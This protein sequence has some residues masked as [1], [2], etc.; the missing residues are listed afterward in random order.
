MDKE[1]YKIECALAAMK[2]YGWGSPIGV[3]IF[4]LSAGFLMYMIRLTF[5]S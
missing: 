5:F 4:F 1:E 2:W 3:S